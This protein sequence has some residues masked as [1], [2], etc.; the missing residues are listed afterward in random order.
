MSCVC[1]VRALKSTAEPTVGEWADRHERKENKRDC[2]SALIHAGVRRLSLKAAWWQ[3]SV[4]SDRTALSKNPH[5]LVFFGGEGVCF[6]S[7]CFQ[8][9]SLRRQRHHNPANS[10][11][12][13]FFACERPSWMCNNQSTEP[14]STRRSVVAQESGKSSCSQT[15]LLSNCRTRSLWVICF[16]DSIFCLIEA[17]FFFGLIVPRTQTRFTQGPRK[18]SWVL[19]N[20][21]KSGSGGDAFF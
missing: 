14:P 10:H 15:L 5:V 11:F 18:G 9:A 17:R 20:Q 3:L 2:F 7:C 4:A 16:T 6:Y 19:C 12:L 21:E 1:L 13:L 8:T